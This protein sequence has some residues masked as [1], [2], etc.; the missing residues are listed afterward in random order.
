VDGAAWTGSTAQLQSKA[1]G[2]T[3]LI[4]GSAEFQLI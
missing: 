1:A 3:R 4:V 2:L